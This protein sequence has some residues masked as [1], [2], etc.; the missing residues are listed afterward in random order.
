MILIRDFSQIP[1]EVQVLLHAP[2]H[3]SPEKFFT[4]SDGTPILSSHSLNIYIFHF[5]KAGAISEK[6]T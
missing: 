5:K 2:A 1:V 6:A 4:I 3:L